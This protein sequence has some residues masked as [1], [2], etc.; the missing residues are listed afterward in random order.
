M[1]SRPSHEQLQAVRDDLA[2]RDELIATLQEE[3]DMMESSLGA[4]LEATAALEAELDE[5]RQQVRPLAQSNV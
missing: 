5:K 2:E 3:A 1:E 4:A